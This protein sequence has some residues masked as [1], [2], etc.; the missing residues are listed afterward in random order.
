MS[1]S[2][3][4]SI[5]SKV[6]ERLSRADIVYYLMPVLMVLLVAG[7]VAQAEIGLYA[8]HQKFFA[9]FIFFAGPIPLP[10]G[11]LLLLILGLNLTLKFLFYSEWRWNKAGIII[12]HLGALVLLLGGLLT[13]LYAKE[14]YMVI[15]EGDDSPYIY[16]YHARELLIFENDQLKYRVHADDLR[17]NL[18]RGI[19]L[20]LG[21]EVQNFCENC[22]IKKRADFEQS[23]AADHE[24]R[25]FAAFMALTPKPVDK[26]PEANLS[27]F[28]FT[29]SGMEGDQNGLYIA[30]EAMPKPVLLEKDG[31]EYKLIYGKQQRLLPFSLR[32]LDFK[33]EN[34]PGMMMARAYSSSVEVLDGAVNWHALIEMNAPLRYKGYTFYQSSF[35]QSGETETTVLTVVEN[36]GRIFPY[37][38]TFIVALGLLLHIVIIFRRDRRV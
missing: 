29:L 5:A 32:L 30:F 1:F 25:S 19:A 20:P 3:L 11:Y 36:K 33:R 21:I 18:E 7:T 10:G 16:D 2:R 17:A 37:I 6:T 34:Y 22:E 31:H 4:T 26:Q 27:G 9:S 24:L 8:A 13:A 15:A 38:G 12:T 35:D 23:F 28:S 14:G